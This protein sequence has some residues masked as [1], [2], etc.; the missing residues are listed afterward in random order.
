MGVFGIKWGLS[1]GYIIF[2]KIWGIILMFPYGTIL[3]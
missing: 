1:W 2:I 3:V